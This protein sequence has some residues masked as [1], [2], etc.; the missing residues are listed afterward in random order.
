MIEA[1][2]V[3]ALL[4]PRA[5]AGGAL[6]VTATAAPAAPVAVSPGAGW[7]DEPGIYTAPL[8]D[9]DDSGP[10]APAGKRLS[11]ARLRAFAW[12]RPGAGL[13]GAELYL[14]GELMGASPLTLGGFL[15]PA[16][17]VTLSAQAAGF[18]EAARP[19]LILP[20]EGGVAI[21]LL[22][23]DAAA[24]VTAPGWVV[25]LGLVV[26]GVLVYHPDSPSPGLSLAG[27]GLLC[28]GLTQLWARTV[29]LPRLRA[30]VRAYNARPEPE[31]VP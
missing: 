19:G 23:D 11:H 15:A 14:D 4:A 27:G 12:G 25:G 16:S 17:G 6:A 24:G 10:A 20:A 2:L 29:T 18:E 8:D 5:A 9:A 7:A 26:A 22:P 3:L 28:A 13:A 21:A 31:P 30:K 1:L